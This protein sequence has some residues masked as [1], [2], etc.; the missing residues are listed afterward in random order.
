MPPSTTIANSTFSIEF[1]RTQDKTCQSR[2]EK[3]W[4][5]AL[6]ITLYEVLFGTTPFQ[7]KDVYGITAAIQNVRLDVPPR[8]CDPDAWELILGMLTMDLTKRFS[9]MEVL[10]SKYV[11]G[12][13]Q[14]MEFPN[15]LETKVPDMNGTIGIHQE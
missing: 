9:M 6:G 8:E 11:N 5:I 7:G 14:E 12:A 2:G 4:I 3:L 1:D 10:N 15:F 13:P